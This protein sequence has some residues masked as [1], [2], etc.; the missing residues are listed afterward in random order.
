MPAADGLLPGM[1]DRVLL[2]HLHSDHI[3]DFNDLVTM[4]WAMSPQANPLPVIGPAGTQGFVDRTLAMLKD[5]IGWRIEHHDDLNWQP[6]IDVVEAGAGCDRRRGTVCGSSVRSPNTRRYA[7]P[8]AIASRADGASVVIG[9][10]GR[11]CDGLDQLCEGAD[12]Y[13]Q[14]VIRLSAVRAIP[15]AAF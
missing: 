1:I 13:V 6:E 2:T 11:P 14:T 5:D 12:V 4:R 15:A 3:T 8:W 10:D 7:R 9:G